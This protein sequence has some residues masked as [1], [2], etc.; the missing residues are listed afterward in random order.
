MSNPDHIKSKKILISFIIYKNIMNLSN[1]EFDVISRDYFQSD[2]QFSSV[3]YITTIV[4]VMCSMPQI[5]ITFEG[6]LMECEL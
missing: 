6:N 4:Y 2:L 1:C 5:E 3:E